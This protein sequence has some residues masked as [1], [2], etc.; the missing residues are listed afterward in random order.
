MNPTENSSRASA[1]NKDKFRLMLMLFTMQDNRDT[2]NAKSN[3]SV[4]LSSLLLVN[5]INAL[6]NNKSQT[7]LNEIKVCFSFFVLQKTQSS[8]SPSLRRARANKL[9]DVIIQE[10]GTRSD[11]IN[12]K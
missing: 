5:R 12:E 2:V 9:F 3:K 7:Q 4:D 6:R 11:D 10:N 8:L 1:Y